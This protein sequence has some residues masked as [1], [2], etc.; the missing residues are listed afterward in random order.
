MLVRQAKTSDAR[1]IARY[2]CM[3]EGEMVELFTGFKDVDKGTEEI[4]KLVLSPE[5]CRYS[6]ANNL[7]GEIDGVVA[8]SLITF[9]ADEQPELD[10]PLLQYLD[11]R[12]HHL[13][14]LFFEGLP[15]SY[16][17]STMGV[18]PAFR[19]KGAGKAL[20]AAAEDKGRSLGFSQTSLLV[21]TDKDRARSLYERVGYAV[22][23]EIAIA[24][25]PYY[26]MAKTL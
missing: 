21:S 20:M 24:T 22:V 8:G 5:P 26:R 2:I 19:G 17:L 6:L 11:A 7:V 15:G 25:H 14:S 9:P 12:G 4:L 18:D 1:S 16:Y 3:A 23:G 10:K 13:D